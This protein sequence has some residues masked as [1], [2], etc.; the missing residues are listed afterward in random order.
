[1]WNN[2]NGSLDV[3]LKI[4]HAIHKMTCEF[5]FLP[6]TGPLYFA[7]CRHNK[8]IPWDLLGLITRP[9]K[10]KTRGSWYIFL[11]LSHYYHPNPT[12]ELNNCKAARNNVEQIINNKLSSHRPP[13][14]PSNEQ[15]SSDKFS[16]FL[17]CNA[18][19]ESWC[20]PPI[21]LSHQRGW[22]GVDYNVISHLI[23][24]ICFYVLYLFAFTDRAASRSDGIIGR[25]HRCIENWAYQLHCRPFALIS[26]ELI[27]RCFFELMFVVRNR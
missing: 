7:P 1:M 9:F 25:R 3:S 19:S 20:T 8:L 21:V 26:N 12:S 24:S 5:V 16:S 11:Y 4:F 6:F 14:N 10:T 17:F 13:L 2:K 15:L 27:R 23:V 22:H 18:N